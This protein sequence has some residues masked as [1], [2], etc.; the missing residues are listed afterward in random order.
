[1][2]HPVRIDIGLVDGISG[3]SDGRRRDAIV[4]VHI[5]SYDPASGRAIEL[6]ELERHRTRGSPIV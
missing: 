3:A 4:E 5:P 2:A 1:M 6:L